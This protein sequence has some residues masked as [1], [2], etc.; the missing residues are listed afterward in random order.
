MA[1]T[2]IK[3][4]CLSTAPQQWPASILAAVVK[5][6][7]TEF[8]SKLEWFWFTHYAHASL[9]D[10]ARSDGVPE[11]G[12]C[13]PLGG[14]DGLPAPGP[15]FT[16]IRFRASS[17]SDAVGFIARV[18]QLGGIKGCH[19]VCGSYDVNG[20]IGEPRGRYTN[21]PADN[22]ELARRRE[23]V[24]QFLT[25]GCDLVLDTVVNH[26]DGTFCF[27]QSSHPA[28]A[29]FNSVFQSVFHL[30]DNAAGQPCRI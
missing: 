25:A 7:I 5:P 13:L 1:D 8:R 12:I 18:K 15:A 2:E 21:Q 28:N 26:A 22:A 17:E 10:E 20:D 6:G 3:I 27:E 11:E 24:L 23:R 16:K 9:Q 29:K 14:P 30:I 19:V 4:Y